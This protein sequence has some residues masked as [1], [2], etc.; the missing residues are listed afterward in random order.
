MEPVRVALVVLAVAVESS[1]RL[2]RLPGSSRVEA[3]CS[4][5][6]QLE[7]LCSPS[8]LSIP[9]LMAKTMNLQICF[10]NLCMR[11]IVIG[12]RTGKPCV[13]KRDIPLKLPN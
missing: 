9:F 7:F 10:I 1:A 3:V 2:G 6:L 11:Q 5:V 13:K 12:L 8:I 4:Y